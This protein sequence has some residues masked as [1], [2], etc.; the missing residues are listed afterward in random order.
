MTVYKH[1][2]VYVSQA[3]DGDIGIWRLD[4]SNGRLA[5][6][7]RAVA[8]KAVAP[9]A[10]SLDRRRLYAVVRSQPFSVIT[11]AIDQ[12]SGG[13]TQA[14]SAPLP[15]SMP[16]ATVDVGGRYLLTASYGGNKIAVSRI[17]ASGAVEGE[18]CQVLPSGR[19]AHA[20]ITDRSNRFAYVPTL[21][22]DQ[23]MQ[24][25]FD[26]ASGSL[27]P[28]TP[29]HADTRS[30]DGPR[31]L[32]TSPDNRFLYMLCELSGDVLQFAIDQAK[33][34]L[35]PVARVASVPPEAQLIPGK[36]RGGTLDPAA[37]RMIW[38][39]DIAITPD[40][41]HLYTTE[42]TQSR[43]SIMRIAADTGTPRLVTS[44]PTG[45]QPRGICIDSRGD[46]LIASGE[47]TDYLTVFQID[48][49]TGA[50]VESGRFAC[51]KGA[52]WVAIVDPA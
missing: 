11:F 51:G 38:C 43:I 52:N 15:D 41:R 24:L 21:G 22:S 49:A 8:G 23:I 42:R 17:G 13:L 9:L 32:V 3:E 5:P 4:R 16:Y 20:I 39:A 33:G 36:P 44:C 25:T 34:T 29:P 7:G 47:K 14:G 46:V 50:I 31:H 12:A 19:N 18:A 1:A 48:A 45:R 35:S 26:G 2:F 28:N 30:G 37:A 27:A 6:V 10:V 40:G